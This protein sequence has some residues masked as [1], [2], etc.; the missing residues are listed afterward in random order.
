[1]PSPLVLFQ[2][3]ANGQGSPQQ[4]NLMETIPSGLL[5]LN[6]WLRWIDFVCLLLV[7]TLMKPTHWG[8]SSL[9][10]DSSAGHGGGGC[11]MRLMDSCCIYHTPGLAC[12]A[13]CAGG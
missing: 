5:C 2:G 11:L 8:F 1:M 10:A 9:A 7:A 4:D 12:S 13:P 3:Y 6:P